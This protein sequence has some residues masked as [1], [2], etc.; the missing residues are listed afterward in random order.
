MK[1]AMWQLNDGLKHEKKWVIVVATT[2]SGLD[3]AGKIR[4]I[5]IFGSSP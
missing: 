5:S 3:A 1:F 4:L 2:L